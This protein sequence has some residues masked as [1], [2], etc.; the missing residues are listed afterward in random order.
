MEESSARPGE[1]ENRRVPSS[2]SQP[3]IDRIVEMQESDSFNGFIELIDEL[4]DFVLSPNPNDDSPEA[5]EHRFNL[6]RS[7]RYLIQDL[8]VFL[9]P[10]Q[11]GDLRK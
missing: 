3:M 11:K 6:L 4:Q 2:I 7:C 1:G 8:R 10:E 5:I 9:T